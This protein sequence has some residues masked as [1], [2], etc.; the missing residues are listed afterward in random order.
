MVN[1]D[2]S[3]ARLETDPP[4]GICRSCSRPWDLH[5]YVRN[6]DGTASDRALCPLPNEEWTFGPLKGDKKK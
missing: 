6:R 5:H 3:L 1:D 2:G 4:T